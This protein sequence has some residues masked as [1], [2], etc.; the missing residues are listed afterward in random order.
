MNHH[1]SCLLFIWWSLSWLISS[2]VWWPRAEIKV[3]RK[4]WYL[5]DLYWFL[6][7]HF[8]I[9]IVSIA[10]YFATLIKNPSSITYALEYTITSS[11]Q[12]F[13]MTSHVSR[14]SS[15][16]TCTQL[17]LLTYS[18]RCHCHCL[19]RPL[20]QSF[21]LYLL[22][23]EKDRLP[24]TSPSFN[25]FCTV[26]NERCPTFYYVILPW[27]NFLYILNYTC[28]STLDTLLTSLVKHL[29]S[30][31]V[32]CWVGPVNI[33]WPDADSLYTKRFLVHARKHFSHINKAPKACLALHKIE[34]KEWSKL[35]GMKM[36]ER[37][38]FD[39]E[40]FFRFASS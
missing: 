17:D 30:P 33:I 7:Y 21:T 11:L 26:H 38:R 6:W 24:R 40:G 13:N 8:G 37:E 12:Y 19:A 9:M 29:V 15:A 5:S 27:E 18:W 1:T 39:N 2:L 35:G 25:H 14:L 22:A 4:I 10:S 32:R 28:P 3:T 16:L 31:L 20:P 23:S 34:S 36:C